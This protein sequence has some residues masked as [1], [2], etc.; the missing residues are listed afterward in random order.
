M[1][2]HGLFYLLP[3][4]SWVPLVT[5]LALPGCYLGPDSSERELEE[6]DS[7]GAGGEGAGGEDSSQDSTD[8]G[9]E[10]EG[11]SEGGCS[12]VVDLPLRRLSNEEYRRSVVD[13]FG[14]DVPE[15]KNFPL[16][17]KS[18]QFPAN[19]QTALGAQNLTGYMEAAEAVSKRVLKATPKYFQSCEEVDPAEQDDCVTANLRDFLTRAYRRT[20]ETD[21]LQRMLD[22]YQSSLSEWGEKDADR[23]FIE[24]VLLAPQFLYVTPPY[25]GNEQQSF[26]SRL[27]YFL[28]GG[29]PD[30]PLIELAEAG[31]L[32]NEV[33]LEAEVD[34][35]L[36]SDRTVGSLPELL[37][38]LMSM[39]R[40]DATDQKTS[41]SWSNG[42]RN[43][44]RRETYEFIRMVI[45]NEGGLH[46]MLTSRETLLNQRLAKIYGVEEQHTGEG[47]EK[48][49]LPEGARAGLLT[50]ASFLTGHSHS[51]ETS[52]VLR[53]RFIREN[54]LCTDLPPPPP[55]LDQ[56][57]PNDS[58]RLD[59]PECAACHRLMDPIGAA[60]DRYDALGRYAE[61]LKDGTE[62][63]S[64]GEVVEAD[65]ALDI[66]GTFTSPVALIERMGESESVRRCV[67]RQFYRFAQRRREREEESCQVTEMMDSFLETDGDFTALMRTIALSPSF[68]AFERDQ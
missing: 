30:A 10:G 6:G 16:D 14:V 68:V 15:V 3:R 38:N 47:W 18:G 56:S 61:T 32:S 11:E 31:E 26:A 62:I 33:T 44:M 13:L 28:T 65:Q 41:A 8:D 53:G 42:L 19:W 17:E 7:N 35:L 39:D 5:A 55:N 49:M 9:S 67:A 66:S 48:L 64:S 37:V 21:E 52:W 1:M 2:R 36:N 27:S 22:F 23:M 50:Q 46:E 45:E 54:L 29:P 51:K 12:D 43:D 57:V 24:T 59:N 60:F 4:L 20:P 63:P 25:A 34:R 40:L 58:G